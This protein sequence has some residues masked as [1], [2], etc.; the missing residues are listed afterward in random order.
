[1][2]SLL[3]NLHQHRDAAIVGIQ[4]GIQK[5]LKTA[6]FMEVLGID[7]ENISFDEE[8]QTFDVAVDPTLSFAADTLFEEYT[9]EEFSNSKAVAATVAEE[10][11]GALLDGRLQVVEPRQDSAPAAPMM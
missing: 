10:I 8:T 5:A 3:E 6:P 4:K 7:V 11:Y 9:S 1:M 2:T